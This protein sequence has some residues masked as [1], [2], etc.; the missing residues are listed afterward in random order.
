MRKAWGRITKRMACKKL[1]PQARGSL[2]RLLAN[3]EAV[4]GQVYLVTF[5]AFIVSLGAS[6]WKSRR[7][8]QDAL[9]RAGAEETD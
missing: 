7:D 3:S 9:D 8:E 6:A 1:K 2:G 5:V 4:I